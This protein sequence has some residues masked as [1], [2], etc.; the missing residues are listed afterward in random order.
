MVSKLGGAE[1]T[2]PDGLEPPRGGVAGGAEVITGTRPAGA[3]A[4]RGLT[5][6]GR[7]F[8]AIRDGA[9]FAGGRAG[10]VAGIWIVGRPA[11]ALGGGLTGLAT[12]GGKLGSGA[13]VNRGVGG[14]NPP[15]GVGIPVG[16]G[17]GLGKASG[18]MATACSVGVG[19]GLG[20]L[21]TCVRGAWRK[22]Y[23]SIICKAVAVTPTVTTTKAAACPQRGGR[24]KLTLFKF[25]KATISVA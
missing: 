2:F 13:G 8:T 24:E 11:W 14:T 20:A 18:W 6:T 21:A 9:E 16:V 3:G 4:G 12:V 5:G 10:S 1:A 22:P 23:R 19:V 17:I 25:G 15:G 7:G